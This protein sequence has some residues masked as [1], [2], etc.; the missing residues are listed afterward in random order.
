LAKQPTSPEPIPVED[1]Y[2]PVAERLPP[3]NE[4]VLVWFEHGAYYNPCI[5]RYHYVTGGHS[6][7]DYEPDFVSPERPTH[8]RSLPKFDTVPR[9]NSPP[10]NDDSRLDYSDAY[11]GDDT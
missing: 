1:R 10:I 6:W 8:W 5:A 4:R 2:I 11:T 7:W 3:E 9:R